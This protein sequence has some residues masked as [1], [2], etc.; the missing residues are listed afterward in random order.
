MSWAASKAVVLLN[1]QS[2]MSRGAV[3]CN[4]LKNQPAAASDSASLPDLPRDTRC[5]K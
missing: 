2:G 4:A 3:V 1:K 5:L